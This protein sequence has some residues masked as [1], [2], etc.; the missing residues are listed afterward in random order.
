MH[1]SGVAAYYDRLTRWNALARA[2]GYG[3][4]SEALTVHRAL[5]DPRADGRTTRS[6]LH[7]VI[8]D[9]LGDVTSP[10]VLDA[11]C[12]LGGTMIAL[13]RRW[14]GH[15]TGVTLSPRQAS[16]ARDAIAREELSASMDVQL[17]SYDDP[18][19]GPFDIVLAIE[20][21]VHSV[22][23]EVSLGALAG[24]L[25]DG[26]VLVIVDD[27]PE[28]EA[29]GTA[30]LAAFTRG[31]HCGALWRRDEYL[32]AC[33]RHGLRLVAERDLTAEC[34]PRSRSNIAWLMR[35]N[36]LVRLWPRRSVQLVMDSHHGG[37]ALERLLSDRLMRYR[38]LI[39]R[40]ERVSNL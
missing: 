20:S 15:Y 32:A 5:A 38:L 16:I 8:G 37:L 31:W 22:N 4:G 10:S 21:L 30:D 35:L 14:G 27:M 12:G 36:R 39:A 1:G 6:R 2:I 19:S 18:P 13:A 34:R 29:E 9:M 11:G 26:G 3:G 17:R 25:A 40:K 24:V 7:D 23:P 28:A 33:S